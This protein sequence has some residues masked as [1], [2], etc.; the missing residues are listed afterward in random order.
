MET[1]NAS[2]TTNLTYLNNTSKWIVK[3]VKDETIVGAGSFLRTFDTNGNVLTKSEYGVQTTY[4]YLA[5]GDIASVTD[6]KGNRTSFSSYKRGIAQ[7]ENRPASVTVSRVIND[8]GTVQS[9]KDGRAN[10]TS[11]TY[12]K[13][14]RVTSIKPPV[15][16]STTI[17]WS[18]STKTTRRGDYGETVTFNGFGR[19]VQMTKRN[20]VTSNPQV[21]LTINYDALGRKTFESYPGSS[22]GTTF[23]YDVL[24]RITSVTNGDTTKATYA[25]FSGNRVD[26]TN[27]RNYVTSYIYRAF[28]DPTQKLLVSIAAPEGVS[29]A[30]ERDLLGH[31]TSVTQGGFIRTYGYDPN[32]Y[33]LISATDPETGT[34]TY[35]RDA[36]GNMTSRAVGNS[37]GTLFTYDG[38]NRLTFVDYP[39]STPDVTMSYDGNNN[40][41]VVDNGV[42]RRTLSYDKNNN[43]SSETTAVGAVSLSAAYGYDT[44][45]SLSTITYPSLRQVSYAPDVL[46]RPTTASPYLTAVSYYPNGVPASIGYA[47]GQAAT[48]GLNSRQW[49]A[50]ISAQKAGFGFAEDLAYGY[51]GAGNV[52]SITD[53]L[54]ATDSKSMAYDGLDR[55]TAAGSALVAYDT[56]GNIR[57]YS[58]STGSLTYTYDS[59]NRLSS[60]IGRINRNFAYD[61]YGNIASDGSRSFTYDD[62]GNL[63]SVA[64]AATY[65]YDGKNQRVRAQRADTTTLY[66]YG[67]NGLLLGEYDASGSWKKEYAYLGNKLVTTVENVVIVPPS[68]PASISVPTNSDTGR[69][70]VSWTAASGYV[71]GY[72]LQESADST[73]TSPTLVYSGASLSAAVSGKSDGTY[74]YRVRACNTTGCSAYQTATNGVTVALAPPSIPSNIAVPASSTTGS[75]V[76]SWSAVPETVSRYELSESTD[77]TFGSESLVYSSNGV[78][79]SISGKHTG[80]YYYRVRACNSGGCSGYQTGANGVVVNLPAPA[81]PASIS[82]VFDPT[83]GG[84][85]ISWTASS[86]AI[87]QTHY[88]LFIETWPSGYFLPFNKLI[89]SGTALSFVYSKQPFVSTC[90]YKVRAC[91]DSA[92]SDYKLWGQS[93]MQ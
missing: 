19:P 80:T 82:V 32:N 87:S 36:V 24:D 17:T 10:T 29:T 52:T 91:N 13:L 81:M 25:Y 34:T 62:A 51:D 45:D 56:V 42:A 54:D 1:G 22:T 33:F 90:A 16:A 27:E 61:V 71:T 66:F 57:S 39:G 70:S 12:D 74:Y 3:Q 2:K 49:I 60:V 46:G 30:I 68:A 78:S 38:L 67:K 26:V 43:L 75:Y 85:V 7:T 18:G 89:Y 41:T 58:T 44:L 88:E 59:G 48:F 8:T 31:P 14:N 40:L 84:D 79:A 53:S 4:T 65:D 93:C 76:I 73:F 64:G 20:A 72:E 15:N 92:C 37:G 63:R 35:G 86:N 5:T 9:F 28:G 21:T 47:N 23:A 83:A 50:S 69:Y 55:L 6:A 77:S 11:Y